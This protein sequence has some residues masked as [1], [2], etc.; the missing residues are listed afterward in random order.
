MV[1]GISQVGQQGYVGSVGNPVYIQQANPGIAYAPDTVELSGK[2][3]GTAK[4]SI[5]AAIGTAIVAAGAL[6]YG[7]KSGKLA[8]VDNPTKW[9]QKLQNL[10]FNA[11]DKLVQGYD[12][13]KNT[14]LATKGKDM[15]TKG[16]DWVK[17]LFG[18]KGTD[19]VA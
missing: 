11:G 13:V 4:K 16:L 1:S 3:S 17:G 9:T 15:L 5:F 14:D 6:F 8:K 19:T 18:K 7:V 12:K 10:A 2:K